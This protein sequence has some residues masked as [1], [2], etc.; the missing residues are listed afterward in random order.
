MGVSFVWRGMSQGSWIVLVPSE[1]RRER[2][3]AVDQAHVRQ[4]P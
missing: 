2:L 1:I 3:K 4:A